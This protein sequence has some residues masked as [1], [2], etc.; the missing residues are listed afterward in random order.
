[1]SGAGSEKRRLSPKNETGDRAV[2]VEICGQSVRLGC[3]PGQQDR[4]RR[5]A[6]AVDSRA[7]A[8]AASGV[9]PA[10]TPFSRIILMAALMLADELEEASQGGRGQA[11]GQAAGES[12]VR[13]PGGDGADARDRAPADALDHAFARILIDAAQRLETVAQKIE[14]G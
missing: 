8:L 5:L 1:M 9:T 13:P 3:E 14:K 6:G 12:G 10:N 7:K 11:A 2:D 4:I